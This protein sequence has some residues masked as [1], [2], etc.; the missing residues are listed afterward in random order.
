MRFFLSIIFGVIV[1]TSIGFAQDTPYKFSGLMFGDYYSV[2]SHHDPDIKGSN[3]FWFRRIYLTYDHKLNSN[4]ST[5]IR[6]EMGSAGNFSTTSAALV[7]FIKDAYIKWIINPDHQAFLGISQPPTFSV[8]EKVWGYRF[9]EKTPLDLQRWASSRDFGIAL[10]GT[11]D[12]GDDL[13]YNIMFGNGEG[14]KSETNKG[15]KLMISLGYDITQNLMVEGYLDWDD[16]PGST[17]YFTYQLF[18]AYQTDDMA[19]GVQF[20]HQIRG[21]A[22]AEDEK[23]SLLSVFV[24]QKTSENFALVGRVDRMFDPNSRA[25]SQVYLPFDPNSKSTLIIA[26]LDYS[27]ISQVHFTPNIEVVLY[28]K[29]AQD[30]KPDSDI[31]PRITFFCQFK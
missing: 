29:N 10:N 8:I 28:D 23:L 19:A 11:L 27:P 24:R 30:V 2:T 4:F 1:F 22:N 15:K 5:R 16:K 17:D 21:V 3:G 31:I 12:V 7:P 6:L 26:G 9:I 20:A 13:K 18:A 14:E 25:D